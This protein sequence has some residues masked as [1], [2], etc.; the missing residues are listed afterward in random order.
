MVT[1]DEE[2]AKKY[3]DRII[4]LSDGDVIY[5]SDESVQADFEEVKQNKLKLTKK[6]SLLHLIRVA[7]VSFGFNDKQLKKALNTIVNSAIIFLL[8]ATIIYYVNKYIGMYFVNFTNSTVM[9]AFSESLSVYM[10]YGVIYTYLLFSFLSFLFI[11]NMLIHEKRKDIA[12]MKAFG[13]SHSMISKIMIIKTFEAG[14]S[15]IKNLALR[16]FVLLVIINGIDT[17]TYV[18]KADYGLFLKNIWEVIVNIFI[19]L[20]KEVPGT[21]GVNIWYLLITYILIVFILV[22]ESIISSIFMNRKNTIRVLAR[23]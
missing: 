18:F 20:F 7:Q 10:I 5:D 11:F 16:L 14:L 12:V 17:L 21:I 4:V 8:S 23:E 22:L 6:F 2:Y 3:S 15:I 19:S 13:A 1:H 9:N